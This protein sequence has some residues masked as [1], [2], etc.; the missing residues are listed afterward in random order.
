M[1]LPPFYALEA[2]AGDIREW[3]AKDP[4]LEKAR[5]EAGEGMGNV[6]AGFYYENGL[7]YRK[8][9]QSGSTEGDVRTCKQLVLPQQ[10]RQQ[11]LRL[12][13]DVPMAGHMGISRTKD[14]ICNGITGQEFLLKW[15]TT[16]DSVRYVRR[17]T[18]NDPLR[19]R[20]FPCQRLSS[21]FSA[22]QW[23]LLGHYPV[24]RGETDLF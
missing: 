14:H 6:R 11:V 19:L 10:C 20:W 15:Q 22:W 17:V 9:R 24:P 21:R 13:H 12:V 3:Q 8:W 5:E 16:A 1:I 2:T 4:T 7:L 18:Q 23:M